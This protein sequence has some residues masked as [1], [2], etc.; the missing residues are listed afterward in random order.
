MQFRAK[1]I[2]PPKEWGTFEDLCHALFK[3]VWQDPLAQ[4]NG[5]KGQAQHGVDIYGILNADRISYWGIQCKGKES[6]YGSKAEWSE[7]LAEVAKAEKFSPKLDKW[8]FATT[9]PADA[10]LQKAAREL[11]SERS[12]KGL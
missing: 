7:V 4:K 5:R 10:T 12:A 1:Q 9:A 2:A 11:S 6:N 3:C 8:I